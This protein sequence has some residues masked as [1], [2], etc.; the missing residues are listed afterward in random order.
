LVWIV[1]DADDRNSVAANLPSDIA[2]EILRRHNRN[3][4]LGRLGWGGRTKS[5]HKGESNGAF[6]KS[7]SLS[8]SRKLILQSVTL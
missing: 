2:V 6:H 8:G 3:L 5:Q 7:F 1:H 4:T